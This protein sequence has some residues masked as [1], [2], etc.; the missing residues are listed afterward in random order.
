[1]SVHSSGGSLMRSRVG[2][3]DAVRPGDAR[4]PQWRLIT[5]YLMKACANKKALPMLWLS[6]QVTEYS[7]STIPGYLLAS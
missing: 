6:L 5:L 1:V 3:K 2:A 4:A 7:F